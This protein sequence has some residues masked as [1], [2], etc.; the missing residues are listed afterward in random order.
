MIKI[1][2]VNEYSMLEDVV[3]GIA[4]DIGNVPKVSEC[5][6]PK[7]K[8]HVKA[9]LFPQEV[10]L[11]SQ[12]SEFVQV[13]EKY[14]VNVIRPRK[15]EKLNQ[16]FSRDIAFVIENILFIPN[17]INE[18]SK[19]QLGIFD[20]VKNLSPKNINRLSND[21]FIEGGD[22][23][24]NGSD[25]FIGYSKQSDFLKY[26]VA[27]TNEKAVNYIK[28]MFP[29][30]DVYSFELKKDDENPFKNTLH[31]DCCFQTLGNGFLLVHEESFKNKSDLIK[32]YD[33]F[34]EKKV[35][36]ISDDEMYNLNCNLFSISEN[37]IVS[38]RE[39]KRVNILLRKNNFIVEEINF[40]EI[41]KLGGL[42]RCTSLPLKRK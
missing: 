6:D 24:Q 34:D 28:K 29:K 12:L 41:S 9:K 18:R 2:V 21:V 42:F 11:K 25:I 10:H 36:K 5:Y 31:L 8:I 19:E 38:S 16:I 35:I 22:I 26:K 14:N 4:D 40:S 3:L 1:K 39:F 23:I 32:I 15:I 7:T 33:L 30:K 37:V 13:L 27:R 17:I 20:L